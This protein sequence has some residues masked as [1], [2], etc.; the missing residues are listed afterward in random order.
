MA[1][2]ASLIMTIS[3]TQ[4]TG[5]CLSFLWSGSAFD[6][7]ALFKFPIGVPLMS[8]IGLLSV[9]VVF[10]GHIVSIH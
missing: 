10:P 2:Q 4:K 7:H 3:E 8:R 1:E 6:I 5:S 9:I